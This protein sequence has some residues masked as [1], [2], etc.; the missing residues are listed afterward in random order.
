MPYLDPDELL[1]ELGALRE[2]AASDADDPLEEEVDRLA[3]LTALDDEIDLAGAARNGA[4]LIP[5]SE[6]E[7]YAR[8]LAEDIGA[9]SADF[10]WPMAHIDWE[11]AADALAMDYTSVSFD[12]DDYYYR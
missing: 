6:F 11:A 4:T 7:D 8:Q 1:A 12:G 10:G 2:R 9:I 3:A 5:E